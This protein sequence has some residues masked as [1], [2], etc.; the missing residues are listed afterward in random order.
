MF[1]LAAPQLTCM[2]RSVRWYRVCERVAHE[3]LLLAP[4]ISFRGDK[5]EQDVLLILRAFK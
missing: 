5:Q 4:M 1:K 3:E 2:Q